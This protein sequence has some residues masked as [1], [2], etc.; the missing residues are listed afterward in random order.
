[1]LTGGDQADTITGGAGN[2]TIT[3]G[4]GID[5]LVGGD[6][7]NVFQYGATLFVTGETVTGGADTDTILFTADSQTVVDANF[8]NK[9]SI[10]AITTANGTNSIT[11]EGTAAT[12]TATV[13]SVT[14]GT[15]VDI[16]NAGAY[17]SKALAIN[18]LG[19]DDT[20]TGG[21]GNDTIGGGDGEDIITGGIGLDRIAGGL[22]ADILTGGLNADIFGYTN[23]DQSTLANLDRITD[24]LLVD[25]DVLLSGLTGG[26]FVS[27]QS[28]KY[29]ITTGEAATLQNA[30]DIAAVRN[31]V[32]GGVSV[33]EWNANTYLYREEAAGVTYNASDLVIT[34]DGQIGIIGTTNVSD[35]FVTVI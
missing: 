4:A 35:Y 24:F 9:T 18:G 12:A 17:G 21:S 1:V 13:L 16:I 26:S 6:G 19:G 10:N 30:L 22:N 8:A 3:G 34:L 31:T 14:G 32:D 25:D 11:L 7:N 27:N 2:D 20:I 33:F 23:E 28:I 5:S 29:E 15:G